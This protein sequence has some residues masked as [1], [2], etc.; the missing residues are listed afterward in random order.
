MSFSSST[1]SLNNNFNEGSSYIEGR[2]LEPYRRCHG[3]R[4]YA[5]SERFLGN[6]PQPPVSHRLFSNLGFT[7]GKSFGDMQQLSEGDLDLVDEPDQGFPKMADGWIAM[8][9]KTFELDVGVSIIANISTYL[10]T[11]QLPYRL[12]KGLSALN[13]GLE[14]QN[15][16]KL[17]QRGSG[18]ACLA[19][20]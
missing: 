15:S 8:I 12:F 17:S 16:L 20:R 2:W 4:R 11:P 10:Q 9:L 5:E 1:I 19:N 14:C 6:S 18:V 3:T 7:F 13:L